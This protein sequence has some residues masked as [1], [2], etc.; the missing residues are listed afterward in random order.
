MEEDLF[1][2]PLPE[3][4]REL[5]RGFIECQ[6]RGLIQSAK[7]LAEM[8]QGLSDIDCEVAG[9]NSCN[10]HMTYD[11]GEACLFLEGIAVA[12]YDN[13][14]LAKSYFDVRE[15]DRAAYF[16]RNCESSVPRFLHIYATYLAKEK[17]RLDSTTDRSNL[18]DTGHVRDMTDLLSTLRSEYSHGRLDGYG[19]YLYGVVLK[20]LNLNKVA[21]QM[22]IHA[23]RLSPMLWAAYVELAPLIVEKEKMLSL[24]FGGH[25]MRHFFVAHTYIEM[26]LNDEGLKA[27]EDLQHAGFRKSVYVTSQMALAYHNKRDVDRAIEIFQTLQE[28]DP[29]RLENMDTYSNLLFVKELKTEMAQLA[30]KAVSI[31]KYCPETCCVVGN[32]YSIR[33]DHQMAIVYFQRALKL[34]PKYLSAWTLMGHEFMELKNTNAAI[35]SYR[36]AVEVNKR[37]YRAWYGLGQSYEILKMNYYSLYYF[38]IAHQLRPYDSRMLVALGETYEKLEKFDNAIKCYWKACDVGDIEGV[39][40]WKLGGLHERR[41]EKDDAA[42]CYII[43][44]DDERATTDKQNLYHSLMV[45]ATYF[46]ERGEFDKASHYAYKCLESDEKKSEAKALL[47]TIENKRSGQ[48]ITSDSEVNNSSNA[49]VIAADTSS[50]DDMEMELSEYLCSDYVLAGQS[51]TK[52]PPKTTATSAESATNSHLASSTAEMSLNESEM[53][54]SNNANE[55]GPSTSA[56]AAAAR[57]LLRQNERSTAPTHLESNDDEP[58]SMEISSISID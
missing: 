5:R 38:K 12:E 54:A 53:V 7:W 22:F 39:A 48:A 21:I 13:Y 3:V 42:Q 19:I 43:F 18:N 2:M 50:D 47:K 28:V 11:G 23:I 4:K 44:S 55:S 27:Y 29:Y 8:S 49:N 20:S 46:E 41:G 14:F 40:M 31:N 35:Q 51:N 57:S 33:S 24:N 32:Y 25:W 34:N 52:G 17:K 6:K 16:V 37:D 56:A 1:N 30:H 9:S 36:K 58:H 26:Y 15:Y 45:L 10:Q